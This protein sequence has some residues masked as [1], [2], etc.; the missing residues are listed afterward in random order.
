MRKKLTAEE[1]I[2]RDQIMSALIVGSGG[3]LATICLKS[4]GCNDAAK[5]VGDMV[6]EY[7]RQNA[8]MKQELADKNGHCTCT[9]YPFPHFHRNA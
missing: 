6:I 1:T 9:N 2:K 5:K 3:V 7:L 4:I 8:G